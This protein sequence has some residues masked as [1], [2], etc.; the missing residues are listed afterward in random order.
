MKMI[1]KVLCEIILVFY[2]ILYVKA[3]KNSYLRA[4]FEGITA[5]EH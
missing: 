4:H 5:A 3:E 1:I 2:E